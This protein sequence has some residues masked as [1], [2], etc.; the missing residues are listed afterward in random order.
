MF[1]TEVENDIVLEVAH[2]TF[3]RIH[4]M[5]DVSPG[6]ENSATVSASA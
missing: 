4:R 2:S 1:G 6:G 5:A 3:L